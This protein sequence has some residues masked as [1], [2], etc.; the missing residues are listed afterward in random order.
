MTNTDNTLFIAQY[1]TGYGMKR[2]QP[3]SAFAQYCRDNAHRIE[4]HPTD[5]SS[6][7][8]QV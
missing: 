5:S 8:R 1:Q 4:L 2:Y 3:F 6:K 7:L